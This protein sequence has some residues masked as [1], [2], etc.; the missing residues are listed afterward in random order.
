MILIVYL[1]IGIAFVA[2]VCYAGRRGPTNK[3]E[4]T[5]LYV[6]MFF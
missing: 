1:L 6:I 5:L 3:D 2:A 4:T